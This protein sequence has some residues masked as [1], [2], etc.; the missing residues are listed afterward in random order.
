M[1]ENKAFAPELVDLK[2]TDYC[3]Y[4]CAFCYQGSTKTGKHAS[5]DDILNAVD[6]CTEN[7]VFEI[8]IGGGEPT[9]HPKFEEI[10]KYCRRVNIQANFTTRNARFLTQNPEILKHH[11]VAF[12]I[13]S[14]HDLKVY[15]VIGEFAMKQ[16]TPQ[17]VAGTISNYEYQKVIDYCEKFNL[18]P[19]VL[20]Y[21]ETGRGKEFKI[22]GIDTWKNLDALQYALRDGKSVGVDTAMIKACSKELGSICNNLYYFGNEGLVSCYIDA[23]TGI[24]GSSSYHPETFVPYNS[25]KKQWA[26]LPIV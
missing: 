11:S 4:G 21:K 15:E 12:S 2:I 10:L 1:I 24:I 23:V 16:F 7:E 8:A 5:L 19:M 13:S 17:I 3:S 25:I 22:H 20:G 14:V 18:R 9:Q 6:D 26:A